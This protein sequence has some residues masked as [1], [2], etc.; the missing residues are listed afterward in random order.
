VYNVAF[1]HRTTLK[2]MTSELQTI[3]ARFDPQIADVAITY[4]S[5]R[6]GDIPHSLASIDKAKR[7]LNYNPE[8][9]FKTGLEIATKWYFE[10]LHVYVN[11]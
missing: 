2:E 4:G 3:L 6:P 1:G 9:D 8:F 5:P 10:N 7:L 11:S